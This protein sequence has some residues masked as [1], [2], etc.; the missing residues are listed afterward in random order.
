M[1][2]NVAG[3]D[4]MCPGGC[5]QERDAAMA[6]DAIELTDENFDREVLSAG[7]PVLVDFWAPWCGPCKRLGPIIEELAR[8]LAGKAKVGKINVDDSPGLAARYNVRAIP[9]IIIFR[10]GE[11]ADQ[12]VGLV[13]KAVLL[14][15]LGV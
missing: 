2:G 15:K 10:D 3:R 8:E 6:V 1:E 12:Q 9:T 5:R 11:V 7:M 13:D 4:T 14:D